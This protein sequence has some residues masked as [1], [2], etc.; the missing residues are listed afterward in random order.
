MTYKFTPA[1][2][3]MWYGV[4]NFPPKLLPLPDYMIFATAQSQGDL[5]AGLRYRTW[6]W[7]GDGS[8]HANRRR[9]G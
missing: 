3:P 2:N 7:Q 1:C 8:F 9:A 5:H 6:L 4:F